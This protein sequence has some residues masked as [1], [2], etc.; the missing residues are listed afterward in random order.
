MHWKT[1]AGLFWVFEKAPFGRLFYDQVQRRV[2]RTIPRTDYS[3]P[4]VR[5]EAHAAAFRRNGLDLSEIQYFEFGA[6]WD[7]LHPLGLW[8]MGVNR[9]LV[10]DLSPLAKPAYINHTLDHFRRQP[11]ETAIR[12]PGATVTDWVDLQKEYGIDYQAPADAAATGLAD[13]V[14]D[15]CATT[16]TLEHIPRDALGR[17][18][19]ELKRICRPG[20]II[21]M[22]IDYTDH[23]AHRGGQIS[24]YN[25]LQFSGAEWTAFNPGIHY[26]NR[27]R[28]SD[29]RKL[30]ETAG[31]RILEDTPETLPDWEVQLGRQA[32][33]WDFADYSIDDLAA[34]SGTFVLTRD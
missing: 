18:L 19:K 5:T 30:F 28:H 21:S 6:G 20:A 27:L 34:T 29:F 13:G 10:V 3:N 16:S 15:A 33:S 1:K 23:Y 14:I 26:Q 11:P 32:I 12:Q 22:A 9:Q 25:F 2:T 24:H 8:C 7:L 31:F 17:I 4:L